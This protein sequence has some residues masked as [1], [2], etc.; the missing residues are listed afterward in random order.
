MRS[1]ILAITLLVSVSANA[2]LVDNG[3][4]T[5]DTANG[6]DWLDLDQTDGL[7]WDAALT[8]NQGWRLATNTEVEGLFAEAF[9]GYYDTN[10][11]EHYSRNL[12][13][14]YADQETDAA[15]WA[16]LFGATTDN[17]NPNE[18]YLSQ[19]MYLDE[20]GEYRIIGTLI[21]GYLPEGLAEVYGLEYSTE[22]GYWGDNGYSEAGVLM[23]RSSVVPVPAAVWLFGSALA[24]LGWFRRKQTA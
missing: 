4:Y 20:D 19:G 21:W 17:S 6:L 12:D 11:T 16:S 2:A 7:A 13:G 9:D 5:T 22:Y 8:A 24:G 3:S 14:S 15:R 10:L 18:A 23:V 1:I